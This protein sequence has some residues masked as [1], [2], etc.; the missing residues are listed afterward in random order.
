MINDNNNNNNNNNN[1][2]VFIYQ[3]TKRHIFVTSKCKKFEK[4]KK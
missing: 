1:N 3:N 4:G 2:K